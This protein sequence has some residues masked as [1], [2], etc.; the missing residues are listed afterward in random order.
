MNENLRANVGSSMYAHIEAAP[1]PESD[2][3]SALEALEMAEMLVDG[4]AWV[5]KRL[6]ELVNHVFLK[7][8]VKH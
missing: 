8:G 7:P 5:A 3:Q 6:G 4:F 1:M 2:R